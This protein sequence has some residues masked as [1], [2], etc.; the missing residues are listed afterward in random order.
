[1]PPF[2]YKPTPGFDPGGLVYPNLPPPSPS[3]HAGWS[4][5]VSKT[6][7]RTLR[8]DAYH[9][10]PLGRYLGACVFYE[11]LFDESV[12]DIDYRPDALNED[13]AKVLRRVAHETLRA[14]R[15]QRR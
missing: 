14:T 15:H 1:L 5:A 13:E 4:W 7:K 11:V 10:S 3:L 8:L 2:A 6:G 9:A 12:L